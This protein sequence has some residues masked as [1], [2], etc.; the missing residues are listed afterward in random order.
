MRIK[1]LSEIPYKRVRQFQQAA[2]MR[3]QLFATGKTHEMIG[4]AATKI[5]DAVLKAAGSDEFFNAGELAQAQSAVLAIW[6]E[7]FT[8]WV[9]LFQAL[10][11][12]AGSIPFG[13]LGVYHENYIRP[14]MAKLEEGTYSTQSG[15]F[16]PQLQALIDAANKRIYQDGLNLSSRIWK[17]DREAREGLSRALMQGVVDGK[18]AWQIAQDVEKFLGAGMDCPRWTSTRLYKLTKKDI[19]GGDR[20]G[21]K[22]GTDCKGQG[23][24]Y[25]A[26]RLARTE[27]QAIHH[28][29]N[30]AVTKEMPWVEWE[31]IVLSPAHPKPDICDDVVNGGEKGD[32]VYKVGEIVLPLHPHCLCYKQSVLMPADQFTDQLRGWMRGESEWPAMDQYTDF[33][34]TKKGFLPDVDISQ[35]TAVMSILVWLTGGENELLRAVG[36]GL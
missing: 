7:T 14:A 4:A 28:L 8:A 30:D 26:L 16:S 34:G 27:L 11:W 2:L 22:T 35:T 21:L 1:S 31:R 19:A 36:M 5:R 3:L 23:V 33:L 6:Q 20:R 29:A 9:T 10:R 25:N 24:S 32:G 15:V 17:M 13:T 18:S 12:Q